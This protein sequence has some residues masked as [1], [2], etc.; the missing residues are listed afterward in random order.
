MN[1]EGALFPNMDF[2]L[3][4]LSIV[5]GALFGVCSLVFVECLNGGKR[6]TYY[7]PTSLPLQGVIGGFTILGLAWMVSPQILGLGKTSIQQ[8]LQ[9]EGIPWDLLL[10]KMV[11]TTVTLNAGGSGGIILPICFIG[12]TSGSILGWMLNQDPS[13]FAAI[14]L[15][16]LLAGSINTP[17]NCR[18]VRSRMVWGDQ[19]TV[20]FAQLHGGVFSL[21]AS[22][23]DSH[24]IIATQKGPGASS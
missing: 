11:T 22:K 9:G 10:G 1:F 3:L 16:S 6:V 5:A 21:R 2:S 20:S 19:W 13:V 24:P 17:I 4:L 15:V 14:G 18:L 7:F 12:A 23:C 8:A